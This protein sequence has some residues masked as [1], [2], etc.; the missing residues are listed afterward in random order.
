[1]SFRIAACLMGCLALPRCSTETVDLSGR[2]EGTAYLIVDGERKESPLTL[3]LSREGTAV[4]GTVLWGQ[5][6]RNITSVQAN[7]PEIQLDCETPNDRIRLQG[8]FRK[9]ALE[10]RFWI[11]YTVDPEPFPGRFAVARKP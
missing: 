10:G 8:L 2:W 11:Q 9:D 3:E 4:A 1:M 5:H 6:L 7:G